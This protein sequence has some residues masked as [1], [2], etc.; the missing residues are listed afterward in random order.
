MDATQRGWIHGETFRAEIN[1]IAEI[2]LGLTL[3]NG[4]ESE[5]AALDS[6]AA[7]LPVLEAFDADLYAELL[8]IAAG[9]HCD[10]SLIVILNQYT[11]LR[12][13]VRH[14]QAPESAN[15]EG[16]S[17]VHMSV[18]GEVLL[19]QTW[20][21]H[22]SSI[23][24]VVMLHIPAYEGSAGPVPE[25]WLLSIV[26]CLGMAGMNASGVAIAIN[27]LRSLDANIGVVWSALVRKA[28]AERTAAGAR[29]V[30]MAAPIGAGHHYVVADKSS[31]FGIETSGDRREVI[32]AG[33]GLPYVHTN[34]CLSPN[35]AGCS[36]VIPGSTTWERYDALSASLKEDAPTDAR[37]LWRQL[38]SH[39]GYPRSVCSH[40]ATEEEPHKSATCA[41]ILMR[42]GKREVWARRGCLNQVEP[43]VFELHE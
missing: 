21:M 43:E 33:N 41:G 27:N 37:G 25:V 4:F 7:H 3:G 29:D 18:D 5:G 40:L 11:D 22:G 23:P 2:R 6:A 1:E 34:H 9:A 28:L 8:G 14:P 42:I 35:V 32:Y 12:D 24:Y 13:L 16:C 39:V 17:V 15:D 10:P 36:W 38:G 20:D 30:I 31:V 26:G 19:A